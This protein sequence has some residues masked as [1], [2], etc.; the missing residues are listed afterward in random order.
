MLLTILT[1]VITFIIVGFM[2]WLIT[3]YLDVNKKMKDLKPLT[4]IAVKTSTV[5]ATLNLS[6]STQK[7]KTSSKTTTEHTSTMTANQ[8]ESSSKTTQDPLDVSLSLGSLYVLRGTSGGLSSYRTTDENE[9][10]T[11][12]TDE[13]NEGTEAAL[14]SSDDDTNTSFVANQGEETGTGD[15]LSSMKPYEGATDFSY[16]SPPMQPLSTGTGSFEIGL[17]YTASNPTVAVIITYLSNIMK[18]AQ[19]EACM[20]SAFLESDQ[21]ITDLLTFIRRSRLTW[22]EIK[23]QMSLLMNTMQ[24]SSTIKN[25]MQGVLSDIESLVVSN[26]HIDDTKLRDTLIMCKEALCTPAPS[27]EYAD[28][29]VPLPARGRFGITLDSSDVYVRSLFMR[30]KNI[31]QALFEDTVCSVAQNLE[32]NDTTCTA[33][34]AKID[35][36]VNMLRD[37]MMRANMTINE[38]NLDAYRQGII[39]TLQADVCSFNANTERI[40]VQNFQ[41]NLITALCDRT[42]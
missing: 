22:S 24:V 11:T 12:G 17:M 8:N 42:T 13:L 20:N 26:G 31:T 16:S 15:V 14:A 3:V 40:N 6:Q 21:Q 29:P 36:N 28:V 23:S 25:D 2:V 7:S 37:G 5:P 18:L 30:I 41:R 4:N 27:L 32:P 1:T 34:L 35:S 38:T 9:E 10:A 19:K 33:L 39:R